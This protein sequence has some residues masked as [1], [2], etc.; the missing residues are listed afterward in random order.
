MIGGLVRYLF[1]SAKALSASGVYSNFLVHFM[2]LKK[3]KAFSP[4]LAMKHP[5]AAMHPARCY[6]SLRLRGGCI[7]SMALTLSGFASIPR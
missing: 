7:S 3:G 6:I 2:S 1:S 4:L 5:K